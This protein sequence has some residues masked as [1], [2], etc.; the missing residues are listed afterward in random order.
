MFSNS[1]KARNRDLRWWVGGAAVLAAAYTAT[2]AATPAVAQRSVQLSVLSYNVLGLPKIIAK[3]ERKKWMPVIARKSCRFNVALFQEDFSYHGLLRRYSP[4][5]PHV[6]RGPGGKTNDGGELLGFRFSNLVRLVEGKLFG[7][8]L[9]VFSHHKISRNRSI[10][11][12]VCEGYLDQQQDCFADKGAMLITVVLAPKLTI[13]LYNTHLDAGRSA[14]NNAVRRQQL[15]KLA[16]FVE[17]NSRNRPVIIAGDFNLN[18][19]LPKMKQLLVVFMRRLGLRRVDR[20]QNRKNPIDHIFFR[21]GR[22]V[23]L[24]V[25][26]AGVAKGF[27]VGGQS[28]SDHQPITATFKVSHTRRRR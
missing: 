26:N 19:R 21:P 4:C 11:Y 9:S 13:D 27:T 1:R 22:T 12:G 24:S 17:A 10:R 18:W 15:A 6:R 2:T 20:A 23:A 8:G 3:R 28:L 7:S 16:S 5:H 25:H 14:P